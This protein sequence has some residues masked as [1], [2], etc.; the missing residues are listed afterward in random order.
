MVISGVVVTVTIA[1][2]IAI[3]INGCCLSAAINRYG[4][5]LVDKQPSNDQQQS[6]PTTISSNQKQ[7]SINN[8]QNQ[9]QWTTQQR[10]Q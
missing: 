7:Q 5:W 1:T 6:E 9:Q 10:Q 4:Q 2:T 3:S 8:N